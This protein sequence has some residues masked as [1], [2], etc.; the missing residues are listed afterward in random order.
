MKKT[1]NLLSALVLTGTLSTC[2]DTNVFGANC[3][4]T[5][6]NL[7]ELAKKGNLAEMRIDSFGLTRK[8]TEIINDNF[9]YCL[10][11][12]VPE[13]SNGMYFGVINKKGYFEMMKYSP[14]KSQEI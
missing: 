14:S 8:H 10:I 11:E 4:D 3:E 12:K 5:A 1:R 9:K 6:R 2:T 7:V 13:F